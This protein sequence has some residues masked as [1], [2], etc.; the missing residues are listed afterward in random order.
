M[1]DSSGG[2]VR[3]HLLFVAG[4]CICCVPPQA[5]IFYV[6]RSHFHK[7]PITKWI[8]QSFAT[9]RTKR[10]SLSRPKYD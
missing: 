1:F 5:S 6:S 8:R 10:V 9:P 2:E 3:G 7:R 4:T